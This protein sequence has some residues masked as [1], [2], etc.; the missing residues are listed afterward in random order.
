MARLRSKTRTPVLTT[1]SVPPAE[2]LSSNSDTPDESMIR[3]GVEL[4]EGGRLVV[5]L[6]GGRLVVKL[7]GVR[8]VVEL[9]GGRGGRV[10]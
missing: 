6:E 3:L 8:L 5:K 4:G 9:E 1:R 7:E 10:G 2:S